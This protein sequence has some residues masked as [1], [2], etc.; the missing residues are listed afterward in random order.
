[1]S[2]K[3]NRYHPRSLP[4]AMALWASDVFLIVAQEQGAGTF[5]G[6]RKA[7]QLDHQYTHA[8]SCFM[9]RSREILD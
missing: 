1:M 9:C 7:Q 3:A 4:I 6:R 5:A 2:L 8:L